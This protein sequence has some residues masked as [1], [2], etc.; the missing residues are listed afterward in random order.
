[1]YSRGGWYRR[2]VGLNL[3]QKKVSFDIIGN[4]SFDHHRFAQG[5]RG[6]IF[7]KKLIPQGIPG[8]LPPPSPHNNCLLVNLY[9][10]VYTF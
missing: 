4:T 8:L 9:I 6:G 2:Q 7:D 3:K 5:H 1:M 10:S